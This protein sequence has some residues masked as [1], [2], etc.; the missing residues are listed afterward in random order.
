MGWDKINQFVFKSTLS[1]EGFQWPVK[2]RRSIIG[3]VASFFAF[4]RGTVHVW[5]CACGR[6]RAFKEDPTDRVVR[7]TRTASW[8][9]FWVQGTKMGSFCF[10]VTSFQVDCAL[11]SVDD[12]TFAWM[13]QSHDPQAQLR[14]RKSAFDLDRWHGWFPKHIPC[15]CHCIV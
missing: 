13:P 3:S 4:N 15:I 1:V 5:L 14:T 2:H 9:S 6:H 8:S 10:G 11:D 12:L 7:A